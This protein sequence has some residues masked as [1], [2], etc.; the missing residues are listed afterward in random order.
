[1]KARKKPSK[2]SVAV[3]QDLPDEKRILLLHDALK[4]HS[5][6]PTQV[7]QWVK[8]LSNICYDII[9][10]KEKSSWIGVF[11]VRL[12]GVLNEVQ[13]YYDE[14][15]HLMQGVQESSAWTAVCEAL[16]KLRKA[17]SDEDIIL[18]MYERDCQ[19]HV[20]QDAYYH[21]IQ[22]GKLK[23]RRGV[24][25]LKREFSIKQVSDILDRI[26]RSYQANDKAIAVDFAKKLDLYIEALHKTIIALPEMITLKYKGGVLTL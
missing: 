17:L 5:I 12:Y 11:W 4:Q 1:M 15:S 10:H 9:Q 3:I 14:L 25:P 23:E 24:K 7:T 26:I 22:G 21:Q 8:D 13:E 20:F 6:Q 18:I 2:G 19:S 16:R